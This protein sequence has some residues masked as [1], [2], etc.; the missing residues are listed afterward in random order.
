MRYLVA[1]EPLTAEFDV[2]GKVAEAHLA[3]G[4]ISADHDSAI[5]KG[6]ALFAS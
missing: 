1:T 6:R 5:D 2:G 4:L 3:T